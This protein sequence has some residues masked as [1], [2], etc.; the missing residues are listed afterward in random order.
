MTTHSVADSLARPDGE[1]IAYHKSDG[2]GPGVV[3]CGG[4]MSD[5][6][7]T[8]AT[9]LETHCRDRGLAFVR[10]DY[11]G[12]GESSG[13]FADKGCISRWA[14]DAA[15]VLDELTDG[16][17]IIVGSSMGGWV[18][19]K[20]ALARPER[21]AGLVGIAPAPDFTTWMWNEM[22]PEQQ[23]I[24]RRDGR[25]ERPTEY[26]D[27][28]YVITWKLIEDGRA[29]HLLEGA[30]LPVNVPVRLLHGMADPDVPW[31]HSLKIAEKLATDNVRIE[32]VKAGDH[33]LSEPG[34]IAMLL[35]T[36]DE[37]TGETDQADQS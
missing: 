9:A 17:Q 6:T 2:K 15:Q 34:D 16:P 30:Q 13:D 25:L 18:M 7:G 23:T 14:D 12:H 33:R 27:D 10:F 29:N 20:L 35:R 1:T 24:I 26:G 19:L 3:F 21:I 31:Q 36:I 4:F 32:F 11:L 28:P 8:K 22:S 5:M 37:L